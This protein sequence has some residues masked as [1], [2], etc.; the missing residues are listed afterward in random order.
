MIG[1]YIDF[2]ITLIFYDTVADWY[3]IQIKTITVY[4]LTDPNTEFA[5][6]Y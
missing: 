2:Y 6:F 5:Y 1:K 4:I 3:C